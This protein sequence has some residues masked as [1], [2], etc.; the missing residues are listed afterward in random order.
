MEDTPVRKPR[1]FSLS[2]IVTRPGVSFGC[3]WP[4]V[5]HHY[6]SEKELGIEGITEEALEQM[7]SHLTLTDEDFAV[8]AIE[9]KRRRHD[10]TST[11]SGKSLPL[12]LASFTSVEHLVL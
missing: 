12:P 3:G 1:G 9:E 8:A 11:H 2:E 6:T 5:I 4:R 10:V 7:R